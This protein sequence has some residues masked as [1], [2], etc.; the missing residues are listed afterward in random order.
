VTFIPNDKIID[1]F[2]F[3]CRDDFSPERAVA[4]LVEGL[5]SQRTNAQLWC[6]YLEL[7]S[8][9]MS[10]QELHQL[11]NAAIKNSQSYDLFWTVRKF[12]IE[13][14]KKRSDLDFLFMYK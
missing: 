6:L 12:S 2:C 13:N 14:E 3:Y 1:R 9:Q 5:E 8:W 10:S 7:S 11:C 4:D